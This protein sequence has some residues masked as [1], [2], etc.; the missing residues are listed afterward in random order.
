VKSN[1]VEKYPNPDIAIKAVT[2]SLTARFGR[3]PTE[4]EIRDFV[5]GNDEQRDKIWNSVS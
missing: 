1:V 2:V 5:S 4:K 3:P